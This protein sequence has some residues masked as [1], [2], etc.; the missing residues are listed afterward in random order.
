MAIVTISRGTYSRGKDVAEKVAACMGYQCL[1]KERLLEIATEGK[2]SEAKLAKALHDSPSLLDRFTSEVERNMHRI[3]RCFLLH[4]MRDNLVYHGLAGHFFLCGLPNVFKV[5]ITANMELRIH[6]EIK[7]LDISEAEARR[8]LIQDDEE[9]RKWGKRIYGSDTWD[10]RLYDMTIHIGQLSIDDAAGIICHAAQN[11][12]FQT[13]PDVM[14]QMKD[15]LL[16]TE[17]QIALEELLPHA[18]VTAADGHVTVQAERER[19]ALNEC[20]VEQIEQ[21]VRSIMGVEEVCVLPGDRK[22]DGRINPFHNI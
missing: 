17:I 1:S 7:R 10:S 21:C 18:V 20:K 9:R 5:R 13:T 4:A 19:P 8:K 22:E 3:R 11:E 14:R 15:M 2:I 16:A 6:E 12:A